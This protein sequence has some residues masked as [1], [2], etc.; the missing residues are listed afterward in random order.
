MSRFARNTFLAAS[1]CATVLLL[2]A[3]CGGGS[4]E[5]IATGPTEVVAAVDL[6]EHDSV[7]PAAS[8]QRL[9]PHCP[10]FAPLQVLEEAEMPVSL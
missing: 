5:P 6:V 3:G 1:A 10:T 8:A 2:A 4:D 7:I 9:N